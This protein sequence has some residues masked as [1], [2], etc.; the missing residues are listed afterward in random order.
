MD[1]HKKAMARATQDIETTKKI[2]SKIGTGAKEFGKGVKSGLNTTRKVANVARKAVS[3]NVQYSNWRDEFEAMEYEFIDLIKPEPLV[4]KDQ[5][6]EN[7]SPEPK[8]KSGSGLGRKT[9][10]S[11]GARTKTNWCQTS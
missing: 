4:T 9:S 7:I 1:S 3:E 6:F 5:V 8:L 11:K 2:A 10:L